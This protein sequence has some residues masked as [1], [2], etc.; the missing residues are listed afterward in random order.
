[1]N[2]ETI[3][4][5]LPE[6]MRRADATGSPLRALLEVMAGALGPVDRRLRTVDA[7]FD[8]RRAPAPFVGMLAHWLDL[9]DLLAGVEDRERRAIRTLASGH[10]R[11]RELIAVA[12][13]LAR[14]RGTRQGLEGFLTI[15]TGVPGIAV[16]ELA[17]RPFRLRVDAPA[18]AHQH[19]ALIERIVAREKP[20][21]VQCEIRYADGATDARPHEPDTSDD[22]EPKP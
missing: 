19:R 11:L 12:A 16:T 15:A 21:C 3:H 20:A 22:E 1:M 4:A 14:Q 10:G 6:V 9:D 13:E 7:L 2:R 17:D 5:L 8:P 18:E